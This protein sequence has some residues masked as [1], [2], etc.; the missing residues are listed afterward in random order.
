MSRSLALSGLTLNELF[1]VLD[2]RRGR[3]EEARKALQRTQCTQIEHGHR[4]IAL[5]EG[6]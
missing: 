2:G 6:G 3:G 5:S 1:V 4:S